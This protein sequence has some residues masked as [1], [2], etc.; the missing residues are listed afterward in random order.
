MSKYTSEDHAAE[1]YEIQR[2]KTDA[3]KAERERIIKLLERQEELYAVELS[4]VVALIKGEQNPYARAEK[5]CV[6]YGD[7]IFLT[8]SACSCGIK[9]EQ[10]GTTK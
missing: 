9:G 8:N 1:A 5:D 6:M 3:T 4:D 10:E 7:D 2:I